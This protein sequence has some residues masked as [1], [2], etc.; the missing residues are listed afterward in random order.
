M[1]AIGLTGIA[2]SSAGAPLPAMLPNLG[3]AHISAFNARWY[4]PFLDVLGQRILTNKEATE[5]FVA[6]G[7]P[8]TDDVMR[9]RGNWASSFDW[10]WYASTDLAPAQKWV[11]SH[12]RGTYARWLISR[13]VETLDPLVT[14]ARMLFTPDLTEYR[15][16]RTPVPKWAEK[17]D[18]A[19]LP[20]N[21]IVF[22]AGALGAAIS[23][24]LALAR[25]RALTGGVVAILLVVMAIPEALIVFH[26]DAMEVARH[27]LMTGIQARIGVWLLAIAAFDYAVLR[28]STV[29]AGLVRRLLAVF[30]WR[31]RR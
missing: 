16:V 25:R 3:P 17:L 21:P 29:L 6:R 19:A 12:G 23:I 2:A 31:R 8:A 15:K 13:P 20:R 7:M 14:E 24:A 22:F 1:V 28:A 4:F 30:G 11:L 18:E 10:A 26:S 5:F 9:F 27:S